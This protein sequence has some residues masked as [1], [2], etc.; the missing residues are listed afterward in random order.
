M[1]THFS[2]LLPTAHPHVLKQESLE[3]M[4]IRHVQKWA[5]DSMRALGGWAS[6]VWL[7]TRAESDGGRQLWDNPDMPD[8][9]QP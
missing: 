8:T 2:S 1:G 9:H 7:N 5:E 6:L 4:K 3:C